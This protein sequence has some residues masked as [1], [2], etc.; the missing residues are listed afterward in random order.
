[1]ATVWVRAT[2]PLVWA[3]LSAL[4]AGLGQ[5]CQAMGQKPVQHCAVDFYIFYFLL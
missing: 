2:M 3:G 5:Q 1:V 4:A